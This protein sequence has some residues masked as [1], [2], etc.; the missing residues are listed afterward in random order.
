MH[1][2]E[3]P[4]QPAPSEPRLVIGGLLLAALLCTGLCLAAILA[5]A[6]TAV[7]PL[8]AAVCVG[9]PMF[10]GW[11]VPGAVASLRAERKRGRAVG[12]LRRS[13]EELPEVEHP[14]GF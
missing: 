3:N 9:G 13:L 2:H 6:P 14:L 7:A 8:V 1:R 4:H 10:A 12:A 5:P 11:Q